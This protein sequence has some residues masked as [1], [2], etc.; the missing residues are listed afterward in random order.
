MDQDPSEGDIFYADQY[1]R[2]SETLP[3]WIQ[4]WQVGK[5]PYAKPK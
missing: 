2:G 3:S 1:G 4:T 5:Q